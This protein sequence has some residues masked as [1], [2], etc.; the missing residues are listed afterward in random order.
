MTLS[1]DDEALIEAAIGRIERTTAGE[2][3][4][5]IARTADAYRYLALLWPT[6]L[7][8]FVPWPLI[9]LAPQLGAPVVFLAQLA[10]AVLGL[11]LMLFS[12]VRL[13]LVPL[14]TRRERARRLARE[15][16]YMQGLHLTAGRTGVLLFVAEGEH[17]A[18]I[19]ADRGIDD[20]VPPGTWDACLA[21]LLAA[22]R[23]G[24]LAAGLVASVEE[25]GRTL[26]AHVPAGSRNP[27]ELANRLVIL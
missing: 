24:R 8:L 2:L 25:I 19:L 18:E 13:A 27:D 26:A 23:A 14:S 21:R 12:P 15:Q 10:T 11:A 17:Y 7:A 1:S 22:A 16:F 5:V 6:I 4:V 20:V 9:A 3:V